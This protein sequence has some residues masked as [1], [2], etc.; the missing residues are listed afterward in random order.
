MPGIQSQPLH[1][2]NKKKN[3]QYV[4]LT[5][6]IHLNE[7]P[8]FLDT[9]CMYWRHW[10]IFRVLFVYPLDLCSLLRVRDK[11]IYFTTGENLDRVR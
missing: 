4:G 3:W 8:E 10:N 9:K 7:L 1:N 6:T 11:V 2:L 5:L